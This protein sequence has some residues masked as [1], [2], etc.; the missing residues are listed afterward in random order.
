MMMTMIQTGTLTSTS[1]ASLE[2]LIDKPC[3]FIQPQG[4]YGN[5]PVIGPS[6]CGRQHVANKL[7]PLG[8]AGWCHSIL[9]WPA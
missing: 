5:T 1:F 7:D 2:G 3:A 8:A 4:F 9:H 6:E